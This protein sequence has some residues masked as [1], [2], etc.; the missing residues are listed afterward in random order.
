MFCQKCGNKLKENITFCPKCGVRLPVADAVK[1]PIDNTA[2]LDGRKAD[3]TLQPIN[4]AK[5]AYE[6]LQE[7]AAFCPKVKSFVLKENRNTVVAA[8]KIN[9]YSVLVLHGQIGLNSFPV[10][11]FVIPMWLAGLS[12]VLLVIAMRFYVE[13]LMLPIAFFMLLSGL[14]GLGVSV[15]GNKEKRIVLSFIRKVLGRPRYIEGFPQEILIYSIVALCGVS[16]LVSY[17]FLI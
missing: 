9:R 13:E 6:L 14:S 15:F 2:I 11:P 5:K 7:N 3:K 12:E 10:F 1:Q 8:G 16:F 4:T 17:G